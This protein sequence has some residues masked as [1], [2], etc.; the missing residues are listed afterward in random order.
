VVIRQ[1]ASDIRIAGRNTQGVRL[2]KLDQGDQISDIACV[3][4]DDDEPADGDVPRDG[5]ADAE[6][7]SMFE[8]EKKRGVK[9]PES[10]AKDA[11]KGKKKPPRRAPNKAA[12]KPKRRR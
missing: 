6:Q 10:P 2:L 3:P 11:A 5:D 12:G 4:P 8:P 1:H 7:I 9:A